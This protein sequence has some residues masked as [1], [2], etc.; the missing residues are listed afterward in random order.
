MFFTRYSNWV[1]FAALLS[2]AHSDPDSICYSYGV[3]FVDEGHYFINSQ[4]DDPFTCVSTFR[5][6][7]NDVADVLFVRPDGQEYFCTDVNTYPQD[8]RM[9]SACPVRKNQMKSGHWM[10]L[11]IGNNDDGYPFAWQRGTYCFIYREQ[12]FILTTLDLYLTVGPQATVTKTP[13]A[14]FTQTTTP[15]ETQ[16]VVSISIF[17][18]TVGPQYT[19][20]IPSGTAK[21]TKTVIPSRITASATSTTTLTRY[22]SSV[23]YTV[24][25]QTTT[26]SCNVPG[27]ATVADKPLTWSPTLVHPQTF[28]TPLAEALA[29]R[30][31]SRADRE[32]DYEWARSRVEAAKRRRDAKTRKGR[33][34]Q[35]RAA[36][37]P[38]VTVTITSNM[39]T[40]TITKAAPAVVKTQITITSS[41]TTSTL[42]PA[43][44]FGGQYTKTIT[45]PTPT[46]TIV[47]SATTTT[48]STKTVGATFTNT[49]TVTPSSLAASCQTQGGRF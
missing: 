24:A 8:Q 21:R 7:N 23:T 3:D 22:T 34:L 28:E 29:Q 44:V 43:T 27:R 16:T 46:T 20:T 5:G 12:H 1:A 41:T 35:R 31:A 4:S 45:M 30:K 33:E 9:L 10:L 42:P 40:A 47:E 15:T 19:V 18:S 26:A 49:V 11:I 6:C 48:T 2:L 13:T 36:D 14:T 39:Q 38:T 17:V 25:T 32:V 37:K